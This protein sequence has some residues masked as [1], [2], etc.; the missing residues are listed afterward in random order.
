M[1]HKPVGVGS[2]F[3]VSAGAAT[4]SQPFS[5]YTDALRIVSTSNAFIRIE[6]DPNATSSD[7]YVTANDEYALAIS[8]SSS[9]VTGITTGTTTTIDFP[10]GMGSPFEVGDYVSLTSTSQ[11]YYNFTHK[12]VS[13]VLTNSS[14]GGY[15]S[16]R[17]IVENN[18]S[19]I[20]TAYNGSDADMR[21]SLKVSAYGIASGTV[22]YQQVQISS[23]A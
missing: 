22:Y 18:S 23:H 13:S 10:E 4:T 12:R 9:R 17:I 21:R 20:V 2:S 1:A 14:V 15:Y 6:S 11:S 5:V 3:A 7:Y 16:R 19:G 8:P